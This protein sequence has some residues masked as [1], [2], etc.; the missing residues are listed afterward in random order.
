MLKN[1]VSKECKFEHVNGLKRNEVN[2]NRALY[3]VNFFACGINV[4]L[5][6]L[7]GFIF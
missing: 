6:T 5:K 7:A 1:L 2:S 3:K 4:S